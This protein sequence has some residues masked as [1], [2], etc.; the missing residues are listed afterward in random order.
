L[1]GLEGLRWMVLA[2]PAQHPLR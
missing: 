1:A 2:A